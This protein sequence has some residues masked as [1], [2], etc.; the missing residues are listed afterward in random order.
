MAFASTIVVQGTALGLVVETASNTE[1]GRISEMLRGVEQLRTPLLQQLDRAGRV[2]AAFIPRG[3]NDH[4]CFR[5]H[6]PQPATQ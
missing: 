4:R 1:I 2:L 3:G 6:C 5:D